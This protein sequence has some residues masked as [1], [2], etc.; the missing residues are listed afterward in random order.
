M[1]LSGSVVVEVGTV[2]P[3]RRGR[4]AQRGVA[5]GPNG[6]CIFAY[7]YCISVECFFLLKF[8]SSGCYGAVGWSA[9]GELDGLGINT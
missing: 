8:F 9:T 5:I 3:Q 4:G 6:W 7:L 2:G 1:I